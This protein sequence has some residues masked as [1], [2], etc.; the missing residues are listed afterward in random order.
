MEAETPTKTRRKQYMEEQQTPPSSGRHSASAFSSPALRNLGEGALRDRLREAYFLLKE[1]EK[2]LFLAASVGQ[3]L[4]D[5]NQQLQDS[6]MSVRDELAE[7]HERL[8]RLGKTPAEEREEESRL[9]GRRRSMA[10]TKHEEQ[11]S[12]EERAEEGH[13]DDSS[14]EQQWIKAHLQPLKMQLQVAQERTDDLLVEREEMMAQKHTLRQEHTAAQR[15]IAEAVAAAD[16]A[17][18]RL[19]ATEEDKAR[20]Q[21]ELQ[22][23]RDMW[24]KRWA[25]HKMQCKDSS[26]ATNQNAAQVADDAAAR[27]RAERRAD[28][29][30][31]RHSAVQAE[32]ELLRS[33]MQRMEEERINEWEPMRSRWLACEEALQEMQE[34]HQSTCEALAQAEARLTELDRGPVVGSVAHLASQKTTTSILGEVDTQRRRAELQQRA[35]ENEH[36]ALK[37]AY[38]RVL[39]SQSRMKQQVARLTQLAATGASEA[40]MKRL[41]AALGEAECQR[42][43]LLWAA[44]DQRHAT[45]LNGLDSFA[46]AGSSSGNNSAD[47]TALVLTLRARLKQ[48]LADRDQAQRELRTAH[49]LRANEIQRTG[50]L[51]R[52]AA[53]AETKLRRAM[54]N[55][56]ALRSD[57]D[58]LRRKRKED[59][60]A[61]SPDASVQLSL[62]PR[63]RTRTRS[64]SSAVSGS[65]SPAPKKRGP[66]S[67]AFVINEESSSAGK[68]HSPSRSPDQQS[69]Q[70]K[71]PITPKKKQHIDCKNN[72]ND[73][74]SEDD[75]GLRDDTKNGP[76]EQLPERG[77][78]SDT[79]EY[80]SSTKAVKQERELSDLNSAVDRGLKS[81][82]G[83]LGAAHASATIARE[84]SLGLAATAHKAATPAKAPCIAT[85]TSNNDKSSDAAVAEVDE[86]YVGSQMSQKPIE[87]TNQ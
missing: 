41:E 63:K 22:D 59:P 4:V 56:T 32:L 52:E 6:Y 70:K 14:R 47:G 16:D 62:P 15:R 81:W 24:A 48:A 50:E 3:E 67:L 39:N 74:N 69:H 49:L 12:G 85:T 61:A 18:R 57:C 38:S 83:T 36:A 60:A 13:M 9:H 84:R 40:R 65:S 66:M 45:S 58:A 26:D 10:A 78:H 42:Q 44:M 31:I 11:G 8:K 7:A 28:D 19:E 17:R 80:G 51:E 23:Q 27:L 73:S 30:Q 64:V 35:L 53:E 25:D 5:T 71:R 46:A 86:I 2:N 33:Q 68:P 34:T 54:G 79:E 76:A 77:T 20:L 1:K 75:S 82:L 72:I 29:L 37:R 55:I 87:C 43:A 21:E